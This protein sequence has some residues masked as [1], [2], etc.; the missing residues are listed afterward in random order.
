MGF[1]V[2]KMKNDKTYKV[3][4]VKDNIVKG[5]RNSCIVLISTTNCNVYR[6]ARL[7]E[8]FI[9][10]LLLVFQYDDELREFL[11]NFRDELMNRFVY[12]NDITVD[13]FE[14]IFD[15]VVDDVI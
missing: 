9:Y 12:I 5:L 15:Q 14:N 3:N 1:G 6:L 10:P 4:E 13:T 8:S 11:M 7:F 2:I